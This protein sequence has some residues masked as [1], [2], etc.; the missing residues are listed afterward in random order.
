MANLVK[1]HLER[2]V[3]LFLIRYSDIRRLDCV[4]FCLDADQTTSMTTFY[5]SLHLFSLACR[6]KIAKSDLQHI[7]IANFLF[8]LTVFGTER[9]HSTKHNAIVNTKTQFTRRIRSIVRSVGPG[10]ILRTFIQIW[11][12]HNH[13]EVVPI[14]TPAV[15]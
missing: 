4:F 14:T 12:R 3:V 10:R 5:H 8:K 2:L 9:I 6:T 11:M 7:R 15:C 13:Q 1:C